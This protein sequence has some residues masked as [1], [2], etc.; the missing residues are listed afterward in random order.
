MQ[1][2]YI[3]ALPPWSDRR[4]KIGPRN[5]VLNEVPNEAFS[6]FGL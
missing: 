3:F 5:E 4:T 2:S 1:E 6:E